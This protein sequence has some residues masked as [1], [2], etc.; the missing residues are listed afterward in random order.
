M[1]KHI[2]SNTI[3]AQLLLEL[4]TALGEAERPQFTAMASRKIKEHKKDLL[5]KSTYFT[6][7]ENFECKIFRGFLDG[8]CDIRLDEISKILYSYEIFF[9]ALIPNQFILID[10]HPT[11]TKPG[12]GGILFPQ[13]T[14]F[15]WLLI[16]D[17]CILY[18]LLKISFCT[19]IP[20]QKLHAKCLAHCSRPDASHI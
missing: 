15:A 3:P 1:I 17:L 8:V 16:H 4:A 10:H 9:F 13:E 18:P 5:L 11:K 6:T 19:R 14:P 7:W 12:S 2:K 20:D